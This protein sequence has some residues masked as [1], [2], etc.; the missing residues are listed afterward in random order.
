MLPLL[1][2]MRKI[3]NKR[4]EKAINIANLFERYEESS[5]S[6]REFC[7]KEGIHTSKFYYWKERYQ[8]EGK[9]G[10]VDRRQG[11]PYKV[12]EAIKQYIQR[13]KIKDPLKSASDISELVKNKFNKD[14][15]D[16]HIQRILKELGL[17]DPVGRKSGKPI[18]KT[19]D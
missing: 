4:I 17:N 18:K 7:K 8:Q 5:L 6:V 10:L 19:S 1:V 11:N 9:K 15:S 13:A 16:R 12:K 2:Y 14:V 3:T